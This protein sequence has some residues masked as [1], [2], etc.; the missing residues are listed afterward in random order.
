MSKIISSTKFLEFKSELSPN[1]NPWYYVRR[2]NDTNEHDSAVVLTVIVRF[3]DEY[4]FLLL[5]TK[6]PPIYAEN[7]ALFSIESPA[8]L[9]GDIQTGETLLECAKKELR[10]ETGFI[11]SKMFLECSNCST[12]NGLSSETLSFIT[13]I[14]NIEDLKSEPMSD[15]GIIV[16]RFYVEV[17]KID[18]YIESLNNDNNKKVFSIATATISG[19]YFAKNRLKKLLNT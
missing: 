1:G 3:D 8:G 14:V 2:T 15:G 4:K 9:I 6:R 10:E 11:N 16:E 13:A 19:I 5:K 18:K 7:K 12:S 17:D